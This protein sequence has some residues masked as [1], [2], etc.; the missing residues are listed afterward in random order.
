M[1][2]SFFIT[3]T[4]TGIG[5]TYL[6]TLLIKEWKAEGKKVMAYKPIISGYDPNDPEGDTAKII[7]ALGQGAPDEISP[8]RFA[9]PLSPDQAA[10]K[11]GRSIDSE[12][13][14]RFS[15]EVIKMWGSSPQTPAASRSLSLEVSQPEPDYVL[16]EGVGGVMVPLN[17]TI[18]VIEWIEALNIPVILVTGSYLGS[19]SHTL[20]AVEALTRRNI[21]I[22]T[23]VISESL[24]G[25]VGLEAT[26]DS[27]M[28]W[29]PEGLKFRLLPR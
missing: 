16:I 3:S 11:E 29:L 12:N 21:S 19:L 7:A 28:P 13:L 5:K 4:G 24:E 9:A 15:R 1:T 14:L 18:R 22:D 2:Q 6:T 8:W 10:A 25:S 23:L 26:R 27:L 20:T 17:S